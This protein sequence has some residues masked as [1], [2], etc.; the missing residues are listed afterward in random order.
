VVGLAREQ[1]VRRGFQRSPALMPLIVGLLAGMPLALKVNYGKREFLQVMGLA[2]LGDLVIRGGQVGR[3]R[4][5]GA[6]QMRSP[7]KT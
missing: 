3:A 5:F 6:C 1:E 7:S 2:A 4:C